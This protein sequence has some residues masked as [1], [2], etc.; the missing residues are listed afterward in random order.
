MTLAES[1]PDAGPAGIP[2]T[3]STPIPASLPRPLWQ[4][5]ARLDEHTVILSLALLCLFA[6]NFFAGT[7]PDFWW[8]LRTG[9]LIAETGA[10]PHQ[11][12][13]SY[14]A[15]GRPWVAHEWLSELI[16]FWLYSAGGYVT[17][18]AAFSLVIT[19]A[20]FVLYQL[21]RRLAIDQ[22]LALAVLVL[23]AT[24]HL[25]PW[26]PR[27]QLFTFLLFA[28]FLY[29]LFG[30]KRSGRA[31][32]W[33]LPPLTALWVN[34][35]AGY[36]VGLFLIGLF[37]AGELLNRFT[38]RPAVAVRPLV[39]AGVCSTL[40]VLANPNTYNALLYP[41]GYAGTANAS[42]RFIAEWQS[43][44]FHSYVFFPFALAV[45]LLM[46]IGPRGRLDFTASLLLLAFT[47][48]ALQS[49]RHI[50]LFA[51]VAAPV[52]ALRL[53]E[54]HLRLALEVRTGP[55]AT[56][57]LII[58]PLVLVP[59]L[60]VLVVIASPYSQARMTPS[61]RSY[62]AGAVAYLKEHRPVGN[63]FNTYGWGGYLVYTL[64]PDYRVFID[65][66]AD[67][68]G[69]ELMEE[70]GR[71]VGLKPDWRAV[72]DK[73]AVASV[74][75]EKDSPLAVLLASQTDWQKVYEGE[76]EQVFIRHDTP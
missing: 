7:D 60:L 73:H 67:V 22:T 76:V 25:A 19:L 27:P 4:G 15:A 31:R 30:Y 6:A 10:V 21:L 55:K 5:A 16:L 35:H 39:V 63:L 3:T 71:V 43:V 8:H 26:A 50:P 48:M 75:I 9:Q 36:V 24:I 70:Y 37:V 64:Y 52:L 20:Y 34:L 46:L 47:F 17:T 32:L 12:V 72:L 42:M 61:T 45:V 68:Y 1:R 53:E 66:R 56:P 33:L 14:T 59:A 23:A 40:A 18:E 65:G 44:D 28:V 13:F 2:P 69:D 29:I 11:D 38:R 51:M 49:Q 74:L 58:A 57:L 41:F 54:R 62:P